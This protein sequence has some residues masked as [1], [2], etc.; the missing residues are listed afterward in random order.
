MEGVRGSVPTPLGPP[1]GGACRPGVGPAAL[2]V[3]RLGVRRVRKAAGGPRRGFFSSDRRRGFL[4]L[5]RDSRSPSCPRDAPESRASRRAAS[6]RRALDIVASVASR[7][8]ETSCGVL[9]LTGALGIARGRRIWLLRRCG[10]ACRG[11][12]SAGVAALSSSLA[13]E[14]TSRN[15]RSP[16]ARPFPSTGQVAFGSEDS[17]SLD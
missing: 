12:V 4:K 8:S 2:R 5:G 3:S 9:D 10:G 14:C 6:S 11:V 13:C 17:D 7:A 16:M 15:P 1:V